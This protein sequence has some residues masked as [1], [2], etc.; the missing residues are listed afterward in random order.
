MGR[1][2]AAPEGIAGY[3]DGPGRY[4]SLTARKNLAALARLRGREGDIDDAHPGE[5]KVFAPDQVPGAYI[6]S[7]DSD[8]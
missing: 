5:D 7:S 4:P 3:V 2:L 8:G 6:P 1:G